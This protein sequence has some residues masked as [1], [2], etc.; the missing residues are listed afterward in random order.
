MRIAFFIAATGSPLDKLIGWRL[1]CANGSIIGGKYSHTTMEVYPGKWFSSHPFTGVSY[2]IGEVRR[3]EQWTILDAPITPRE[4]EGLQIWCDG[5]VKKHIGYSYLG[6]VRCG[7]RF[8]FP[9]WL[10]T[11]FCSEEDELGLDTIWPWG[12]DARDIDPN[13]MYWHVLRIV[14]ERC[15]G[16]Q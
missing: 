1:A 14:R 16:T 7:F 11:D 5:Q 10:P 15:G 3:P 13:R 6:A 12:E 9:D 2:E 4:Q 8:M